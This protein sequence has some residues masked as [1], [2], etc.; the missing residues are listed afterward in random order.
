M[1]PASDPFPAA[2]EI[3]YP[4]G[5]LDWVS[6]FVRLFA[7]IPI[8][9]ILALVS[10]PAIHES[11]HHALAGSGRAAFLVIGSGGVLFVPTALMLLF[12]RK[13]P[14][15]WFDWNLALTRFAT[16]CWAYLA[17]LRDEYPSTDEE[18]AVHVEIPYPD[19]AR[20]LNRYLPLVKC[21][22]WRFRTTWCS[23]SSASG[24][25]SRWWSPGS[26]SSS[27]AAI[28]GPCSSSWWGSSGGR[29]GWRLMRSC[30]RPTDTRR[31]VSSAETDDRTMPDLNANPKSTRGAIR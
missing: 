19:A 3:D 17:L 23:G 6:T 16:R 9:I 11:P 5:E 26:R 12:R 30:L 29:C 24:S 8:L 7:A 13:Y 25:W 27:P 14:G 28:R 4:D 10:G 1:T 31:S 21:G 15:W 18:Q 22:F 20:E 2:L